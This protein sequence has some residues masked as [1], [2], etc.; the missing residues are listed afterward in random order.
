MQATQ[1]YSE[2]YIK[3]WNSYFY[4]DTETLINKLNIRDYDLL[5]EKDAEVSFEKLVE[6]YEEPIKC[7][8]DKKH[9]CAIHHFI[10]SELYEWAGQYRTVYMQKNNSYFTPT[11]YI[12]MYL[13]E[14]LKLMN[15]E[16]K[17]VNSK[18]ELAYFLATY[19]VQLL[20]IHPFR[21]GNGRS[22]REFLREFVLE[23]TKNLPCGPMEI[24]FSQ[25]DGEIVEEAMV[26]ARAFRGP[27]EEQ[28]NNALVPVEEIQIKK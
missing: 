6:L 23:K 19:Y 25:F 24:D 21:E 12:D 10:F 20:N 7:S 5:K 22:I 9:L 1:G 14:E 18:Q 26:L 13:N 16:I 28:F 3:A 4:P 27:I 2:E 17:H 8:F 11:E 15:E